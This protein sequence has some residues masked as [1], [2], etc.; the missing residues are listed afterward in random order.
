MGGGRGKGGADDEQEGIVG[1]GAGDV[2]TQGVR[3]PRS[4]WSWHLEVRRRGTG[5]GKC[6]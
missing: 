3:S 5:S 6:R 4:T 1:T 2:N